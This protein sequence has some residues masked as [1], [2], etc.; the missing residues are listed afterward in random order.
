MVNRTDQSQSASHPSPTNVHTAAYV[1]LSSPEAATTLL[2]C[3]RSSQSPLSLTPTSGSREDQQ[4][5]Q[6]ATRRSMP[7][8]FVSSRQSS[9]IENLQLAA[10]R[11]SD[12][13]STSCRLRVI[14]NGRASTSSVKQQ[15]QHPGFSSL[16]LK[17]TSDTTAKPTVTE[18][19]KSAAL[20]STTM[21]NCSFPSRVFN[22][23]SHGHSS[24]RGT[25]CHPNSKPA[26]PPDTDGDSLPREPVVALPRSA[27]FERDAHFLEGFSDLHRKRLRIL[28]TPD[29]DSVDA[30]RTTDR[31]KQNATALPSASSRSSI[32]V[33]SDSHHNVKAPPPSSQYTFS[34]DSVD[35]SDRTEFCSANSP[36]CVSKRVRG[37]SFVST[38][39]ATESSFGI[40]RNHGRL[41]K[42]SLD[43]DHSRRYQTLRDS[44]E[45]ATL[46][47]HT[48]GTD[49]VCESMYDK[50]KRRTNKE[51]K[52]SL[53]EPLTT[54]GDF[55]PRKRHHESRRE[56]Q[57]C[58]IDNPDSRSYSKPY[59]LLGY[60][61]G[62][63]QSR[64]SSNRRRVPSS[65]V[66]A[67]D[68]M[69][70]HS[71]PNVLSSCESS[72]KPYQRRHA[73]KRSTSPDSVCQKPRPGRD[74]AVSHPSSTIT[75]LSLGMSVPMTA[76]FHAIAS[77][78]SNR[79]HKSSTSHESGG[80]S[81]LKSSLCS[82]YQSDS[83]NECDSDAFPSTVGPR[84][85]KTKQFSP[86]LFR[87]DRMEPKQRPWHRFGTSSRH[88][89]SENGTFT[90]VADSSSSR[91]RG[92]SSISPP[93]KR[94]K[95]CK[96]SEKRTRLMSYDDSPVTR[97]TGSL[98]HSQT[99]WSSS[100]LSSD[101]D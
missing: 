81:D 90:V 101:D 37:S 46:P 96:Q 15:H 49:F 83:Q 24:T 11:S 28:S 88:P 68:H 31:T 34:M 65:F 41:S 55:R 8:D 29:Y 35:S 86:P 12:Y 50:I 95:R 91:L 36:G 70:I 17:T 92:K 18:V 9:F 63:E 59:K 39:S 5:Q 64:F 56:Q 93:S 97:S 76:N 13:G 14:T 27:G 33:K 1:S 2:T 74:A 45:G 99:N 100:G 4:Q 3:L 89:A 53:P 43:P 84:L 40:L 22:A 85:N 58:L 75:R 38:S 51:A 69:P 82:T 66:D 21:T 7:V 61:S 48:S 79:K 44:D 54:S 6:H 57:Q 60:N 67:A 30:G 47:E 71:R 62:C 52:E 26:G 77:S 42:R 25:I 23:P 94:Q 80:D 73:S 19:G 78:R 10:S 32:A 72:S 98:L 16:P 20:T 87:G